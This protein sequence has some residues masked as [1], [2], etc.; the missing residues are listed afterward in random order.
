V[1]AKSS[2]QILTYLWAIQVNLSSTIS[3]LPAIGL[4]QPNI[5]GWETGFICGYFT[6][7]GGA[8]TR[9]CIENMTAT[10]G[11]TTNFSGTPSY[12]FLNVNGILY[13]VAIA[14][15]A[16]SNSYTPTSISA[17]YWAITS[18]NPSASNGGIIG[19][20]TVTTPPNVPGSKPS[21]AS[22]SWYNGLAL[23]A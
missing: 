20:L 8:G 16:S 4:F 1:L 10:S 12:Y 7:Y 6:G 18:P 23:T 3:V 2:N 15:D 14:T 19:T 11:S 17:S 5:N 9:L 22:V 13:A 21:Y